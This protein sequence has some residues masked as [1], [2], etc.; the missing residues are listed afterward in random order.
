MGYILIAEKFSQ[1]SKTCQV[2]QTWQVWHETFLGNYNKD[3]FFQVVQRALY[4]RR[5][6]FRVKF[7]LRM[8]RLIM[9][10]FCSFFH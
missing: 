8:P 4:L 3:D 6:A 5:C 9:A 1:K 2:W 7:I 10:N